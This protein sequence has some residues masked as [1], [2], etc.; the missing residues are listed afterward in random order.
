M[1]T[2]SKNKDEYN[3][4]KPSNTKQKINKSHIISSDYLR[5]DLIQRQIK[6][7]ETQTY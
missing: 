4:K 7:L 3:N 5:K 1:R 2:C 6:D